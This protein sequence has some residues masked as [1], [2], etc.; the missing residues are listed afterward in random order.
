MLSKIFIVQKVVVLE[1]AGNH[2]ATW[3]QILHNF[4]V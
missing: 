1:D 4:L 2:L 3:L